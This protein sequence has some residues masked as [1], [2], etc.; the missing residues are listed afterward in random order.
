MLL[1]SNSRIKVLWHYMCALSLGTSARAGIKLFNNNSSSTFS[2]YR[3]RNISVQ[4]ARRYKEKGAAPCLFF[5]EEKCRFGATDY[6]TRNVTDIVCMV[7]H[8]V[9]DVT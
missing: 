9:V 8:Q 6:R 1:N 5:I 4:F 2:F 7:M 3:K